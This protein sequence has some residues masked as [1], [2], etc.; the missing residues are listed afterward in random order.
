M[1]FSVFQVGTGMLM[2]HLYT[3]DVEEAWGMSANLSQE[4]VLA[5]RNTPFLI[6][7]IVAL[8]AASLAYVVPKKLFNK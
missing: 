2:T 8:L 3:P 5:S 7:T 4:V 1:F 6:T